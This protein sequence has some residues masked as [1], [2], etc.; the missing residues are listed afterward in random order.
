MALA[1]ES[2]VQLL[3]S[4]EGQQFGHFSTLVGYV[5][6]EYLLVR[7]P[8]AN[9]LPI[10]LYEGETV[11]VRVFSGVAV[12]IFDV[13]VTHLWN[14]QLGCVQL[15]F[16]QEIR[17]TALRREIRVK[18]ALAARVRADGADAVVAATLRNISV[19]GA[20]IETRQPLGDVAARVRIEFAATTGDMASEFAAT[21]VIRN[22]RERKTGSSDSAPPIREYGIE[23]DPLDADQRI[24]MQNLI[25]HTL[26][27]NRHA[28]V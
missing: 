22:A 3:A 26:L 1:V 12:H 5:R 7:M 15:A 13:E 11:S 8:Y 23:L 21:G 2:R 28:V 19:T 25:Y 17:T 18:V 27:R 14:L 16:P 4:R 9:G 10:A 20:L 24:R 6:D